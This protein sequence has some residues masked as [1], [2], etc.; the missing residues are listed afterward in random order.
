MAGYISY[1]VGATEK[2]NAYFQEQEE[3]RARGLPSFSGPYCYPDSHP[4]L[5]LKIIFFA[6]LTLLLLLV[7]KKPAV[8]IPSAIFTF[9]LFPYWFFDTQR[10]LS[11]ASTYEAG[12]IDRYLLNASVI[13]IVTCILA[14]LLTVGLL[15]QAIVSFKIYITQRHLP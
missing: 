13:D 3:S 15:V 5:L 1:N 4:Q 10:T 7:L 9:G 11:M 6:G 2:R 14:T 12:G 8:S